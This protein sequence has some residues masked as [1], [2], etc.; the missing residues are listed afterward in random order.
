[1]QRRSRQIVE[2]CFSFLKLKFRRLKV[3]DVHNMEYLSDIIIACCCLH[4]FVLDEPFFEPANMNEF[5]IHHPDDD[6]EDDDDFGNNLDYLAE[7]R[8]DEL[9]GFF[10]P[11]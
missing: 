9:A 4:H 6:I 1:M 10:M 8:R 2:R 3:I 7:I 5:L 11:R